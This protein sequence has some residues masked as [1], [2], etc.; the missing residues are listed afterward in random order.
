MNPEAV[1]GHSG[2]LGQLSRDIE[3]GNLAVTTSQVFGRESLKSEV[4]HG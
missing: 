1:Q 3:F 4:V 2:W